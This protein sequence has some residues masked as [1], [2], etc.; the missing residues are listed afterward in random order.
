MSSILRNS[1]HIA[2]LSPS[3][4]EFLDE[5]KASETQELEISSDVTSMISSYAQAHS[6]LRHL[7]DDLKALEARSRAK[8]SQIVEVIDYIREVEGRFPDLFRELNF[9]SSL[10]ALEMPERPKFF[11]Y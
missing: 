7:Q 2:P 9:I 10:D 6:A 4:K 11:M 1:I 5:L 8:E 3:I